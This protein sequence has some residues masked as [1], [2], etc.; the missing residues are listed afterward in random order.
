MCVYIQLMLLLYNAANKRWWKISQKQLQFSLLR[1]SLAEFSSIFGKNR[2]FNFT[3]KWSFNKTCRAKISDGD[4][5]RIWM[6]WRYTSCNRPCHLRSKV[7]PKMLK[8]RLKIWCDFHLKTSQKIRPKTCVHFFFET[9]FC[10]YFFLLLFVLGP[11]KSPFWRQLFCWVLF[12]QDSVVEVP[13]PTPTVNPGRSPKIQT[14]LK[15]RCFFWGMYRWYLLVGGFKH[16]LFSSLFGEDSHFDKYFSNGL[17]P[18]TGIDSTWCGISSSIFRICKKKPEGL[19]FVVQKMEEHW[20]ITTTSGIP[21]I[22]SYWF[23]EGTVTPQN[24]QK[25]IIQVLGK[26][27]A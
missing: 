1:S 13:P 8:K 18:P 23:S 11:S 15:G 3:K 5:L 9:L 7:W 20:Q 6:P 19:I 4:F 26:S 14:N 22:W 24:A 16:F 25:L 12:H 27:F 21:G 10:D 2:S 17:Q